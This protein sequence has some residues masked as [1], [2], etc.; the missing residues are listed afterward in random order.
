MSLAAA[1]CL[2]VAFKRYARKSRSRGVYVAL[3]G[4]V[5]TLL[6]LALFGALDAQPALDAT[7]LGYGTA[8]GVVL[9]V[10]NLLLIESLSHLDVSLGSTIYRLNTIGVVILSVL[11]LHEAAGPM[12]LAGIG[13]G[14]GAVWLLYEHRVPLD[15]ARGMAFFLWLAIFASAL[16]A[17]F[18]VVAKAGLSA[19]ADGDTVLLIYAMTWVPAGL[20]YAWWREG[21]AR[22]TGPKLAYGA[23]SGIL[24]FATANTLIAAL[25]GGDVST[26]APIAN[27]SFIVALL[28][29]AG[30]GMERL[31]VRK[32]AAVGLA[33]L[34]IVLLARVA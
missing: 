3:C 26:L 34:A 20:V 27:L 9:T 31:N 30:L 5:W 17:I 6:Q 11:V 19:G 7:T 28:I 14:V 15:A 13:L 12:K 2:D 22:I 33:G 32:L 16:R 25:K 18:G 1:G 23:V 10:A 4:A 8:A 21:G 24:I 29:S